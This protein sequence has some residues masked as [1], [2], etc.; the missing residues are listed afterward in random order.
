MRW[1]RCHNSGFSSVPESPHGL[2]RP[3]HGQPVVALHPQPQLR[4]GP[5]RLRGGR[6]HALHHARRPP[7]HRRHLQPVVRGRGAQPQADQRSDQEAARHAGLQHRLQ[8]EQR[9]GL[10]RGRDDRRH[11]ARRP[12]QGAVLQLRQRGR[13]HLDEGGA[14]LPPRARRG[15]PQHVH[16]PRARLPRRGFRRHVGGRHSGQPQGLRHQPAAARGPPALHPRSGEPRLH[17]QHRA[18]LER[19]PAAGAGEPHPAAARS[20]QHRG[21]DRRARGRQ[22]G[23]VRAAAGLP[24]APARDL[25]QARHPADLRRGHHR[26]RPPGHARS[27][28]T[29]TAC[30]P[31][32]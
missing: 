17:P 10:S 22:R 14:G 29:T 8:R 25:R 2:Q 3:S 27:R 15:S 32:C 30:S 5:A 1:C 20:E 26:L 28:R 12:E 24:E 31:T 6:R 11:G 9:Q 23:L 13:R 18:G 21:R 19:R 7:G 4:Q 16:R